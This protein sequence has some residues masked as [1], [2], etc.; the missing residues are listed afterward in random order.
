MNEI[1]ERFVRAL[2]K[3]TRHAVDLTRE[4]IV[5]PFNGNYGL[6]GYVIAVNGS[7]P[8]GMAITQYDGHDLRMMTVIKDGAG[9]AK[10]I[11]PPHEASHRNGKSHRE[12]WE[13]TQ[14]L[15]EFSHFP[16]RSLAELLNKEP[17]MELVFIEGD[18]IRFK[19]GGS[20]YIELSRVTN[21]AE[22]VEWVHHLSGKRWVTTETIDEFIGKVCAHYRLPLYQEA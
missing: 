5:S 15:I 6:A 16:V 9:F 22:I 21:H 18:V 1:E 10:R 8:R 13:A 17:G 20:Y 2:Y 3:I 7:P 12:L 4:V 19:K 14:A 11:E